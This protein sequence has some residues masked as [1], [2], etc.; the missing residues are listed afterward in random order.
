MESR[1]YVTFPASRWVT[2]EPI[3]GPP[4]DS[5][6]GVKAHLEPLDEDGP[7][8]YQLIPRRRSPS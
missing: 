4:L 8:R 1:L 6:G 5:S 7:G 3:P 2:A